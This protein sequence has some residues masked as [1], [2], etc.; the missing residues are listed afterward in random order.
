MGTGPFKYRIE[1]SLRLTAIH[2]RA[3]KKDVNY[4]LHQFGVEKKERP[5]INSV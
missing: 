2:E 4:Y 3:I 1:G 5:P